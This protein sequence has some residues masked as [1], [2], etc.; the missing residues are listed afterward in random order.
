MNDSAK[1]IQ[2][3]DSRSRCAIK[4]NSVIF[5]HAFSSIP[6]D[7]SLLNG[8]H[9]KIIGFVMLFKKMK[10]GTKAALFSTK[11]YFDGA[12]GVLIGRESIR[13]RDK[14]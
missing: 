12:L 7:K 5:L 6:S 11:R 14:S 2:I 10:L 4:K 1:F 3:R 9:D 8:Q 13:L